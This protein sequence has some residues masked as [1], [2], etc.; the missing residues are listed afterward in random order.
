M[1][2]ISHKGLKPRPSS[3]IIRFTYQG[4]RYEE[5][6]K[7]KPTIINMNAAARMRQEI[8]REI[9][10]GIFEFS[11]WFPDSKHA[12]KEVRPKSTFKS[13]SEMYVQ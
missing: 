4:R 8:L 2:A 5:T 10:L 1:V 3:I 7:M 9:Q 12:K 13:V 11:E 6:V